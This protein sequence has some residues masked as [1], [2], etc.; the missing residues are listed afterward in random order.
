ML[1]PAAHSH[2]LMNVFSTFSFILIFI[3]R[4][5]FHIR[6]KEIGKE[7]VGINNPSGKKSLSVNSELARN[8]QVIASLLRMG[9][10]PYCSHQAD[11]CRM[12]SHCLFGLHD[13]ASFTQSKFAKFQQLAASL[14]ISCCINDEKLVC[15]C[16]FLY[17]DK[18]HVWHIKDKIKSR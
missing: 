3:T 14:Q 12:G 7:I 6:Q 5:L 15:V 17:A 1:T 8:T 16:L 9:L 4:P 10:L 11:I 2:Q 18:K 13:K